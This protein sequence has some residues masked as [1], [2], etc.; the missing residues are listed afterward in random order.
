VVI[1]VHFAELGGSGG[2]GIAGVDEL[3]VVPVGRRL[4]VEPGEGTGDDDALEIHQ[5]PRHVGRGAGRRGRRGRAG[6]G[7]EGGGEGGGRER[8]KA[9]ARRG[10]GS[11]RGLLI[12][13]VNIP[14]EELGVNW[15][16]GKWRRGAAGCGRG[17]VG[18]DAPRSVFNRV[19][20]RTARCTI[21][22]TTM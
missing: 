10:G 20:M 13:R 15:F 9:M 17:A 4:A 2:Q 8:R 14:R 22:S 5:C 16:G 12:T 1:A 21:I 3:V 11:N 19:D 7:Q 6:G 18:K